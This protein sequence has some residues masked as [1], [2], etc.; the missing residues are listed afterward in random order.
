MMTAEV[1]TLRDWR[2]DSW[3][4]KPARQQPP[5]PDQEE[6]EQAT[7][8]LNQVAPLVSPVESRALR[9]VL[10]SL[11]AGQAL[12]L[13]AGECAERFAEVHK[14]ADR[15]A[16]LFGLAGRLTAG[17]GVPVV[18]LGYRGD[19]VSDPAPAPGARRP[20]ASRLVRGYQCAAA[21]LSLLRASRT[22][23]EPFVS[24]EALLLPYEEALTRH[25]AESNQW[26]ATSGHL[27]WAGERTRHPRHA[28]LEYLAGIANPVA[29]KIG[30]AST[31]GEVDAICRRL[32]PGRLPGRL[33]LIARMGAGHV[34][35]LLPP[36]IQAA[37]AGGHEA[38]WVCDPMHGNTRVVDGYKTRDV[39]AITA[40]IEG[41]CDV[42]RDAGGHPAGLHLEVSSDDVTE[43]LGGTSMPIT[44]AHLPL[45]YLT[46]GDPRLNPAQAYEVVER[47]AA[48]MGEREDPDGTG[49]RAP[50]PSFMPRR[51]AGPGRR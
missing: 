7:W 12:L 10:G 29:V 18:A 31:P 39:A 30:P 20:D 6:M 11:G 23:P 15:A 41:F 46:A 8:Y 25:D 17:S 40:E 34:R 33:T 32:N 21:T 4:D 42:L 45:R 24:H 37:R 22:G 14:T 19:Q 3:R 51:A 5:W 13:H 43:C 50:R 9:C 36:L 28:H 38:G 48:L 1:A 44:A 49:P 26:Y 27:L 2:P 35:R 47:A 16:L